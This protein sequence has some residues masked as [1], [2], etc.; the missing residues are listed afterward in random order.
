MHS[1]GCSPINCLL[2]CFDTLT[3][4]SIVMRNLTIL[5]TLTI[6]SGL[7]N[8]QPVF[9]NGDNSVFSN[10][11]ISAV[12]QPELVTDLVRQAGIED[13]KSIVCNGQSINKFVS[14]YKPKTEDRKILVANNDSPTTALCIAAGTSNKAFRNAVN[15]NQ[16]KRSQLKNL[17][18]NSLPVSRVAKN[19]GG[20]NLS[21]CKKSD[22]DIRN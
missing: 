10:I 14:S 8:A 4:E 20:Y 17:Y 18:C 5:F 16:I 2:K 9:K 1:V 15:K 19:Y 3:R 12:L 7:C 6:L 11:C 22:C 21:I 13:K